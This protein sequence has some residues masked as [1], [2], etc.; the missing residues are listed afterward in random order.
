MK[1][2]GV[3]SIKEEKEEDDLKIYY[4]EKAIKMNIKKKELK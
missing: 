4:I 1:L 3:F 2:N